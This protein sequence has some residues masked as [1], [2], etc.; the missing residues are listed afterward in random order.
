MK[1]HDIPGSRWEEGANVRHA[2]YDLSGSYIHMFPA[3]PE[4]SRELGYL[5]E[6]FSVFSCNE[7]FF[8]KREKFASFM[9]LYTYEG[10]GCL[11]YEG[12]T[13][14]LKPGDG[15]FIDCR[16]PQFYYTSGKTWTHSV[17]HLQGKQM[18]LMYETFVKRWGNCFSM[19]MQDHYQRN[20]EHLLKIYETPSPVREWLAADGISR[21]LTQLLERPFGREKKPRKTEKLIAQS[22]SYMEQNFT[23]PLTLEDLAAQSGISRYYFSHEFKEQ[24]GMPPMVYLMKLRIGHARKLLESTDLTVPQIAEAVG[25][26]DL[27][28]FYRQFKKYAGVTPGTYRGQGTSFSSS[29]ASMLRL[30]DRE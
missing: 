11:E 21:L 4:V 2:T 10:E 12:K 22:V 5:T 3:V 20:L 16:K 23:R 9:L 15:F 13:F 29:A 26:T 30:M 25:I 19:D 8:T 1:E 7:H 14:L 18:R 28:H 24:I 6:A 17:L 27:N